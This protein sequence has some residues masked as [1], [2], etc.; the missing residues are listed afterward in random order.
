MK[1]FLMNF[2]GHRDLYILTIT[3]GGTL[4]AIAN[5]FI[6]YT[7]TEIFGISIG[8]WLVAFLINMI[9]IHTG[10][11]AETVR[12]KKEGKEFRFKSGKGW[13]A[14]EKVAVF[15][16]IIFAVWQFEKEVIRLELWEYLSFVLM[17]I[18]LGAF[19]YVVLIELQSIGENEET[20]FGKKGKMFSLL[21]TIIGIVNEGLLTK[22]RGLLNVKSE[23]NG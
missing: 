19:A 5:F 12:M 20:R 14:L 7:P 9:D 8:L 18:K 4:S 13:R 15:T 6:T 22:I 16:L 1:H 2:I 10:I 23:Q 3:V 21:D 17:C 11:K